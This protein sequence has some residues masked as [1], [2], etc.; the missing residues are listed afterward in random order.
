MSS[1]R[2]WVVVVAACAGNPSPVVRPTPPVERGHALP[3]T[4]ENGRWFLDTATASGGKLRLFLD[5]AGGMFVTMAAARRLELDV[6]RVESED[7]E[8]D[9]VAFPKLADARIPVPEI[10]PFPVLDDPSFDGDGMLGAPWFAE[11]IWTFDYPARRLIV[12]DDGHLPAV[13]AEHRIAVGFP[14]DDAGKP[15]S[16]YG[17]I[18]MTVDGETIDMLFDTGATVDLTDAALAAL[19][20]S[21]RER[22]TCFITKTVFDRWRAAHPAWRVIEGADRTMSDRPAPMIEVPELVVAGY[23]VGP[24]WFTWRPD[25]EF[26]EWMAQ[27]MDKPTE[28]ALG[29]TAFDRFRITVDWVRGAATFER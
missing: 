24:V 6:K 20:G 22:A 23:E 8:R 28:G 21:A 9:V 1:V 12:S 4:L 15:T 10:D 11:R 27:W 16:P 14:R 2:L 29:G 26:H 3:V 18:Q 13:A 25:K 5:S 17:R 19:G 7:G